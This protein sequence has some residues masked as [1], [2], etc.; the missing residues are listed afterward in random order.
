SLSSSPDPL[1][2]DYP[3]PTVKSI[4]KLKEEAISTPTRRA[5]SSLAPTPTKQSVQVLSPSKTAITTHIPGMGGNSP[6]KV[7]VLVEAE[8]DD[9]ASASSAKRR[10]ARAPKAIAARARTVSVP[11]DFGDQTTTPSKPTRSVKTPR[12]ILGTPAKPRRTMK[13]P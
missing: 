4:A 7:R 10:K 8:P 3:I 11:V 6:W 9:G 1:A 12:K 2:L 13:R 5:R